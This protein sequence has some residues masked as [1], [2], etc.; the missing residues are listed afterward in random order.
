MGMGGAAIGYVHDPSAVFHNPAGLGQIERGEV[1]GDF[2]LLVG[3]IHASPNGNATNIDSKTTVAPFFLVGAGYRIQKLITLGVAVYPIASSGATFRFG[4]TEDRTQLLFLEASPAIAVNVL[5]NLR[6]GAGYRVT[7]VHL[8]RYEGNPG[9]AQTPVFDF[10]LSGSNFLGFRVGAEWSAL[11][12]LQFGVVF[13]NPTIT[14]VT[15]SHGT[16]LQLAFNDVSTKFKLP[17]KLGAG[18]RADFDPFGVHGSLA[19]DFE[20]NFNGE[21]EGYPLIGTAPPDSDSPGVN[22]VS[23]VFEWSNSVTLKLGA[24]YRFLHSYA[25]DLDRIAVRAGYV[26]DSKAA[27]PAYP[28]AFGSPPGPSNIGTV[29]AGYNA[30]TWQANVA[31]AYRVGTGKVTQEGIDNRA[32]TCQFCSAAG[33]YKIHLN[34]IYVDASYKF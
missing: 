33:D 23:N 31:Y 21:N 4:A 3:G 24:E 10:Q 28:T 27:N 26:Y 1:L 25:L 16:A 30:G 17:A 19:A 5:P 29:G 11:P 6:I 18:T 20:Y 32:Q 15:N 7:Y 2:S 14:K 8:D 9:T 34:G 22:Q 13:R 12:W